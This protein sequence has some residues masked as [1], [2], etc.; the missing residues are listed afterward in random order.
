MVASGVFTLAIAITEVHW[1]LIVMLL[2]QGAFCVVFYPVG[3]V[4][5]AKVTQTEK[6]GIFTGTIMAVSSLLGIGFIPFIMGIIAD[7]WSFQ[8]GFMLLGLLTLA[9]CPLVRL[10][11]DL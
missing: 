3:I 5:I 10:L 9:I 1:V 2:L 4:A 11:R 7:R 6:R 8:V